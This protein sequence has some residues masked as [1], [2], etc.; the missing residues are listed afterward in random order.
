MPVR[1]SCLS[2][3]SILFRIFLAAALFFS[4]SGCGDDDDGGKSPTL[5]VNV[6]LV[7]IDD[8]KG[9]GDPNLGAILREFKRLFGVTEVEIGEIVIH[10][11]TGPEA[12]RLSSIDLNSG[13]DTNNLPD[14][15][16]E[17]FM[18]SARADK[19]YLNVFFVNIIFPIG[20]LGLAGAINGPGE[21][22]TEL[23][24]VIINT[25]GG[26]TS[27]SAADLQMQGETMAHE[28]GHYLGLYHTTE[29]NGFD[30][31]PLSDTP[32][33]LRKTNDT[34]NDGIVDTDECRLLD[35]P[36]L[37]FWQAAKY[38][39]EIMSPMQSQVMVSHPLV[40]K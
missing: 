20:T 25:F 24:G 31:D 7:A 11:L 1:I 39:Q 32:E 10:R 15:M 28:S 18:L 19:N 3:N 30:F 34:N 16:E 29:K 13:A 38:V 2:K 12:E 17:L 33:C 14:E 21:N 27:L 36:N 8:Y 9:D 26:L 37:M 40:T 5:G 6:W 4:V 35:G 22:G 23:S